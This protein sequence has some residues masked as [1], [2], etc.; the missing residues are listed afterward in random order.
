MHV[1]EILAS[2]V[3]GAGPQNWTGAMSEKMCREE[4]LTSSN[5]FFREGVLCS[6][7]GFSQNKD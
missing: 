6:G 7:D 2:S 4:E 5:S 1:I 3:A